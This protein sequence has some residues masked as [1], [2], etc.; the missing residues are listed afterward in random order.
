SKILLLQIQKS[1][2]MKTLKL[3]L[4]S[5]MATI[6]ISSCE[7]NE[8]NIKHDTISQEES[9]IKQKK[10]E[11]YNKANCEAICPHG[12][13]E[14]TGTSVSCNCPG[15]WPRCEASSAQFVPTQSTDQKDFVQNLKVFISSNISPINVATDLVSSINTIQDAIDGSDANTYIQEVDIY[16]NKLN[17][18][19]D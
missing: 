1:K 19:S 2:I 6:M 8:S 10:E 4:V 3:V 5:I 7:K 18:L 12:D 9:Q 14:A 17:D 15:G 11:I 13:C 16:E